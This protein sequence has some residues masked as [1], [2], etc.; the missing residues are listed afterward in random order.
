M[1]ESKATKATGRNPAHLGR[2]WG[3][4]ALK[5]I[6]I[7]MVIPL[8]TGLFRPD[9]IQGPT[10][11]NF[12]QYMLRIACEGVPLFFFVNGFLLLGPS[13]FDVE[14]HVRRIKKVLLLLM[15]WS[16][17]LIVSQAAINRSPL[18]ASGVVGL[19]LGTRSGSLYTGPLWF[20]QV[21]LGLY[22]LYPFIKAV[23]DGD[24]D[25]RR[26]SVVIVVAVAVVMAAVGQITP[27]FLP[28]LPEH[29]QTA[30]QDLG[31]WLSR[32]NPFANVGALLFF[33]TGGLVRRYGEKSEG[34]M[35]RWMCMGAVAY[36]TVLVWGC[37]ASM[38]AG[39]LLGVGILCTALGGP[40][41]A[42]GWYALAMG[43]IS[44][45]GAGILKPAMGALGSATMGIYLLHM[46]VLVV[47]G[48]LWVPGSFG[49]R[50]LFAAVVL[51]ASWALTEAIKRIPGARSLVSI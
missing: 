33:M 47:L 1:T 13:P 37:I 35:G 22:L 17:L 36:A 46:P 49:E 21:L 19:F 14:K 32:I 40:L 10:A 44:K 41:V 6:A 9:F 15:V 11:S 24:E 4:D 45:W 12:I 20:L 50:L 38:M 34:K 28:L 7:C 43:P 8:H 3:L 25:V 42:R 26:M 51:A 5:A 39:R 27:V 16:L 48:K 31:G 18:T 30:F 29:W 23:F 2:I